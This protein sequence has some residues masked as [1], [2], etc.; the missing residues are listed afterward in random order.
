MGGGRVSVK[1]FCLEK[2]FHGRK[3]LKNTTIEY[4]SNQPKHLT[5]LSEDLLYPS[6]SGVIQE[7]CLGKGGG[8]NKF[9]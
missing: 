2:E 8:F 5:V 1:Y 7:F 6:W 3:N 9:S 4:N